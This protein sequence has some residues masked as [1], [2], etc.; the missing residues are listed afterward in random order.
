MAENIIDSLLVQIGIDGTK[1]KEGLTEAAT[2][3]QKFVTNTETSGES[4]DRLAVTAKKSGLILGN[5]SDD[6]AERIMEIGTA[7]Q[8]ASVVAGK[9]LSNL[10]ETIG[11]IG[12]KI[13]GLGAP[14][15]AAFGGASIFQSFT[16]EG[17]ALAKLSDRLDISAQKID[18]WAKANEDAGG[19][20]EAFK[21]ALE[22]FVLT[23]GKGEKA[24]FEMGEHIK[25][26]NQRQAEYFLQSQGLSADAA[27]VFLKYR[28]G[29]EQAA[30]A[31][32]GVA[33]SDEQVKLAREFN[34]QWNW[35]TNQ[36]SSLGSILLTVVMPALNGFLKL[37]SSVVQY[38]NDHSRFVKL[39]AG[40]IAAVFGGAYLKNVLAAVKSTSLFINIFTKGMPV[41]KAFNAVLLANPLGVMIVAA[42]ALC[43]VLDDLIGFLNGDVS[44]LEGFM[45]WLGLSAKE[46]DNIR[47]NILS[48]GRAII[49][50]P[51]TIANGAKEIWE[52]FKKLSA[53]FADLFHIPDASEAL[54]KFF[55]QVKDAVALVGST[56]WE[57]IVSGFKF[58]DK[59]TTDISK[60]P[61][62]FVK[63]FD[64][65]IRYIYEK[66]LAWFF[67]P[68]KALLPDSF[69]GLTEG[70]K[71]AANK[72]LE[73]LMMPINI[74]KEAIGGL[75]EKITG[76]GGAFDKALS[77]FGFDSDEEEKQGVKGGTGSKA[78]GS[79]SSGGSL[80]SSIGSSITKAFDSA[81]G[82]PETAVV[83]APSGIAALNAWKPQDTPSVNNDMKVTVQ[84][85]VNTSAD[86]NEVG[87]AVASGVNRAMGRAKD[88]IANSATGVV[89]KG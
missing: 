74:I 88:Y 33:M 76:L 10:G 67:E 32:S 22:N 40:V 50:L 30:E 31:F 68:L 24:F 57:G 66:F 1:L 71:N 25:G 45:Q 44:A 59:V 15:L 49:A 48:F 19:S 62:A 5:V 23:T 36:A 38:L 35:F 43:A 20:Q 16:Q 79:E 70:A 28:D 64:N 77:F 89:Q 61:D 55:S 8:K 7:G 27:A 60:I 84:T 41:V 81:F 39:A 26:L 51:E 37:V 47:Q 83:G 53:G 80:W 58:F 46:V 18:M 85:T 63:G 3:I 6:V 69:E 21:S 29:A 65:G 52:D 73:F 82:A 56:I 34:R 9:A 11:S 75:F 2:S 4:V 87:S 86:P 42:L 17:D 13:I 12:E 78:K 72:V 54:G 14:L